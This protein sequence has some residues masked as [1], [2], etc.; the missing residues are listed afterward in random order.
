MGSLREHGDPARP[1]PYPHGSGAAGAPTADRLRAIVTDYDQRVFKRYLRNPRRVYYN[2]SAGALYL[3]AVDRAVARMAAGASPEEAL[4][5]TFEGHLLGFIQKALAKPPKRPQ[6]TRETEVPGLDACADALLREALGEDVGLLEAW[7]D[8]ARYASIVARRAKAH[9]G[10]WQKAARMAVWK[11][12]HPGERDRLKRG[13]PLAM[14]AGWV[15]LARLDQTRPGAA[16]RRAR[17]FA[18][19]R[20]PSAYVPESFPR[21]TGR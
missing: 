9:G 10:N 1:G 11:K 17:R 21:N 18:S 13:R 8:A 5:A 14:G 15:P 7:S 12:S 2:P 16:A 3:E 4:S 20:W 19:A 6:R